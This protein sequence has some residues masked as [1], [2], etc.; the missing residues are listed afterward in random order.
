MAWAV[1]REEVVSAQAASQCRAAGATSDPPLYSAFVTVE[2]P[3]NEPLTQ[4]EQF[5]A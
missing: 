3:D 4:V 2:N 5:G 1:A